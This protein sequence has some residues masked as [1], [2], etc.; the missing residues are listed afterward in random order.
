M[1]KARVWQNAQYHLDLP[2]AVLP[3]WLLRDHEWLGDHHRSHSFS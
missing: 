3:L 1:S 2:T